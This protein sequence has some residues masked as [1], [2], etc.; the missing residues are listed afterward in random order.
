MEITKI[1]TAGSDY[2]LCNATNSVNGSDAHRLLDRRTG[3]GADGLLLLSAAEGVDAEIRLLLPDGSEGEFCAAALIASAKYLHDKSADKKRVLIGFGGKTYAVRLSVLRGRV[4]CAWLT[5]PPI[6]PKPMEQLKYYHG[7]RGEVLRA[8]VPNPRV[9]IYELCG[10]HAVFLLDSCAILRTLHLQS[11]CKKLEEVLFF[12]EK[13]DLHF[14]AICGDNALAMRS[15]RCQA[16]EMTASGEG[17][18]LCT[19]AATESNLCDSPRVMVKCLGGSFCVEL[20]D[21]EASLC[22][23]CETIFIGEAV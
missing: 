10:T 12:R 20:F 21:R 17:A 2:L 11:V 8:C 15:F 18:V 16:G 7:I 5:M 9:S 3:I 6:S 4:L 13:I 19:Y 23:K 22:A 14:A 1:H